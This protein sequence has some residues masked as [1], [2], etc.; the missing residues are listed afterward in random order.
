MCVTVVMALIVDATMVAYKR[1]F[2][3]EYRDLVKEVSLLGHEPGQPP[4]LLQKMAVW[5]NDSMPHRTMSSRRLREWPHEAA[6]EAILKS[7]SMNGADNATIAQ[8]RA[9]MESAR[10]MQRRSSTTLGE[11]AM[12]GDGTSV[13][14]NPYVAWNEVCTVL[15]CGL[16][17]SLL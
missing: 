16:V 7:M 14:V 3:P 6:R 15:C 4:S 5:T 17:Y 13:S 9:K 12:I 8:H 11:R 10:E 1:L 2:V